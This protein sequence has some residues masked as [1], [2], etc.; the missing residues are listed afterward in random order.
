MGNFTKLLSKHYLLLLL[1]LVVAFVLRVF[2]LNYDGLWNDEIYTAYTSDPELSLLKIIDFLGKDIHPPFHNLL[3]NI[4]CRIFGF[5]DLSLRSFSMV[6]GL[7]AVLS[8]YHITKLFFNKKVALYA[9]LL[10][11]VNFYLI[12]YSQ[13]VRSYAFLILITNYSFYFFTL[14]V[15]EGLSKKNSLYYVIITTLLLYTHYFSLFIIG[16]QFFA[17]LFLVDW[18]TIKKD[19]KG[20]ALTFGLPNALFLFWLPNILDGLKKERGAWRDEAQLT[21]V[22]DYA[23]DFFN[24][25]YLAVLAIITVLFTLVYFLLRKHYNL[26]RLE[27]SFHP[28]HV[29]L[30]ILISWT[31]VFFMLPF[32]KSSTSSTIMFNRYFIQLVPPVLILMGYYLNKI[33]SGALGSALLLAVAGY[34]VFVLFSHDNPYYTKTH[35]FREAVSEIKEKDPN[36]Y[37]LQHGKVWFHLEYY[38]KQNELNNFSKG[39][40][41]ARRTTHFAELLEKNKPQEYYGL[42]NLRPLLPQFKDSTMAPMPGYKELESKTYKNSY[43]RDCTKVIRYVKVI[44][45]T[46]SGAIQP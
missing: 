2:H 19:F 44:D 45:S 29:A 25:P 46:A 5:N 24:D 40:D 30:V 14:I 4:W 22:Y 11:A 43:G 34:S 33:P 28:D 23:K 35:M 6:T 1:I 27:R 17:F 8:V 37:V 15:R 32:L 12:R 21:L 3:G 42:L 36:A 31:V 16:A 13:E 39:H 26:K 41:V 18:K 9:T 20:Y 10:A 7:F 38:L